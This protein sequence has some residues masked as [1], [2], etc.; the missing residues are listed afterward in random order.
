[1]LRHLKLPEET[2]FYENQ[3]FLFLVI[4]I[5]YTKV[6]KWSHIVKIMRLEQNKQLLTFWRF[7]HI[8]DI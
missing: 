4:L 3:D 7:L 6:F 8:R 1:M 2:C 5:F